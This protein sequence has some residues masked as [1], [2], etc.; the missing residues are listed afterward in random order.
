MSLD[1]TIQTIYRVLSIVDK[2]IDFIINL[3]N[4]VKNNNV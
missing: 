2:V 1:S 4:G 3:L